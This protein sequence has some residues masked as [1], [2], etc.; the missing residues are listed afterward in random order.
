MQV[1]LLILCLLRKLLASLHANVVR[2]EWVDYH[3]IL[4][5]PHC[6]Y[7]AHKVFADCLQ[8]GPHRTFPVANLRNSL[9]ICL[10]KCLQRMKSCYVYEY[11]QFIKNSK[12]NVHMYRWKNYKFAITSQ[13][14]AFCNT[15]QT[16]C[17]YT[18]LH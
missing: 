10:M 5:W 16:Y 13:T 6:S 1:F 9:A 7:I 4:L 2:K 11:K 18:F 8:S 17:E 12:V 14:Y 15:L 3:R